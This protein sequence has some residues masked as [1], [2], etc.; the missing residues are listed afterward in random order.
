MMKSDVTQMPLGQ[1][2]VPIAQDTGSFVVSLGTHT[3]E[4]LFLCLPRAKPGIPS[5]R[6]NAGGAPLALEIKFR[7]PGMQ[8]QSFKRNF[9]SCKWSGSQDITEL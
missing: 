4:P 5:G 1:R 2:D 6:G 3:A 8:D 7:F 9:P